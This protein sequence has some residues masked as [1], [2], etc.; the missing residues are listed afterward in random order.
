[1]Y[2]TFDAKLTQSV[3]GSGIVPIL[4]K[5]PSSAFLIVRTGNRYKITAGEVVTAV[6]TEPAEKKEDSDGRT[7]AE[8]VEGVFGAGRE[9]PPRRG[10]PA[11][12]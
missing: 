12:R 10:R 1:M 11:K 5:E 9:E 2:I 7:E 8:N 4:E 6:R 3:D